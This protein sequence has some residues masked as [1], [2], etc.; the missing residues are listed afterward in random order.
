M[1]NGGISPC[2]GT[3][4]EGKEEGTGNLIIT[5]LS[6]VSM[7]KPVKFLK[8][9]LKYLQEKKKLE[10]GGTP[11]DPSKMK[12]KDKEVILRPLNM[13]DL[14]EAKNQVNWFSSTMQIVFANASM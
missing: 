12:E 5:I 4:T 7:K 3:D 10:K 8:L 2:E 6:I 13:A 14:K 1:H 9:T 11:L